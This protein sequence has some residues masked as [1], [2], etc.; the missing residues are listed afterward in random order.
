MNFELRSTSELVA[1]RTAAYVLSSGV[2]VPVC[3]SQAPLAEAIDAVLLRRPEDLEVLAR[4]PEFAALHRLLESH[5]EAVRLAE[6]KGDLLA[7][8]NLRVAMI[9]TWGQ[10]IC[11]SCSSTSGLIGLAQVRVQGND[12]F[13]NIAGVWRHT[14]TKITRMHKTVAQPR[15]QTTVLRVLTTDA[16]SRTV[17][18]RA[19]RTQR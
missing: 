19:S 3:L 4:L 1:G 16:P 10:W 7:A 15:G 5:D 12:R 2:S 8:M 13:K 14:A 9:A 17:R 18:F 11:A 6:R